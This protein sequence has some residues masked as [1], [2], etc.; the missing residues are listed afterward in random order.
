[1]G[2]WLPDRPPW[3]SSS[4]PKWGAR[5]TYSYGATQCRTQLQIAAVRGFEADTP[6][7]AAY[8]K[9]AT[10]LASTWPSTNLALSSHGSLLMPLPHRS[11]RVTVVPYPTTYSSLT[12]HGLYARNQEFKAKRKTHRLQSRLLAMSKLRDRSKNL[13]ERRK[14]EGR[15]RTTE[16]P[17]I[18]NPATRAQ[19]TLRCA[20]PR[21]DITHSSSICF[22]GHEIRAGANLREPALFASYRGHLIIDLYSTNGQISG[23]ILRCSHT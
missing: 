23:D 6:Q 21:I 1:M 3:L 18:R 5:G 9:Q 10:T 2:F 13:R 11:T 16:Q 7:K 8:L 12:L 19:G 14:P 20:S 4:S 15:T 22:S 17:D